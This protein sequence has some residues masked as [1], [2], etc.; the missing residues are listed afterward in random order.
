[1]KR[2]R[3]KAGLTPPTPDEEGESA[4]EQVRA[5]GET[6]VPAPMQQDA[7]HA[8]FLRSSAGA[9]LTV[10]RPE[11]LVNGT[12]E[13]FRALLHDTLAFAARI[14]EMRNRLGGLIGLSGA[15]YT[16]LI[17]ISH[18]QGES[19]VGVNSVADH[20][21]LSGAFVTIEVNRLVSLDMVHKEVNPEDRRRV[22]LTITS[23]A[24]EVL[25]T[26]T[27][28]QRPANDA[29]FGHLSRTDFQMLRQVFP[30][31]VTS[32]DQALRLIDYL[33]PDGLLPEQQ[34]AD[35]AGVS[36]R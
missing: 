31:F 16:I 35:E 3:M 11:L 18:L 25:K 36:G 24:R 23:H 30:A 5:E 14:Q 20:L 9:E 27:T 8:A 26:L 1:M 22:L 29:L 6:R 2:A 28:V 7:R 34:V 13:E 15:Q 10:S 21:H 4:V 19:G 17:A 33:A 12:D 32:A